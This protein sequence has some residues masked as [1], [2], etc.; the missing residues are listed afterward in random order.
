MPQEG[1][2]TYRGAVGGRDRSHSKPCR[3]TVRGGMYAG[4]FN[5]FVAAM[6]THTKCR[7]TR[8]AFTYLYSGDLSE[9]TAGT[10]V[11]RMATCFFRHNA[12]GKTVEFSFPEPVDADTEMTAEGERITT[13]AMTTIAGLLNTA[14]G[15]GTYTALYGFV[16]QSR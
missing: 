13:A 16:T 1:I 9:P 14:E 3:Y 4:Q 11:D 6:A 7:I 15:A 12:S 10:N 5:T 2:I 8:S